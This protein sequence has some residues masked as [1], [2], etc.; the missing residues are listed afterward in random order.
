MKTATSQETQVRSMAVWIQRQLG[1]IQRYVSVLLG[2]R[3]GTAQARCSRWTRM[4]YDRRNGINSKG[5]WQIGR[6][7]ASQP[8]TL[9][10]GRLRSVSVE[11]MA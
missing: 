10:S 9:W 3:S 5:G 11:R 1:Q 8:W 4:N 7:I 6:G 2:K